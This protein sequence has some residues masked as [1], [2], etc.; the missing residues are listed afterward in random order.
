[1]DIDEKKNRLMSLD[2]LRGL[3][4]LMIT[5]L[6]PFLVTL[7]AALGFGSESWLPTQLRHVPW[8]G[9]R[10]EDLIF[11]LFLFMAGVTFPYSYAKQR[12]RGS[13]TARISGRIVCRAVTLMFLGMVTQGLFKFNFASMRIPSVLALIGVSWALAAFMYMWLGWRA[14][15]AVCLCALVGYGALMFFAHAPDYPA[16]DRFSMEGSFICWLDRVIYGGH[17]Y[18]PLYDP[19][20]LLR[21][22]TGMVTA[23]LGMFAG[24][25]IR[26][27]GVSGNRKALAIAG[28]GVA[29]LLAGLGLSAAGVCPVVK[30][31]W[32]PTFILVAG[33]WSAMLLAAFYW[34]VDVKMWRRW[35]FFFRVV[36][37]NS[38]TIY[39]AARIIPFSSINGFFLSGTAALLPTAWG[40]V[41]MSAGYIAVCWLF[42]YFLYRKNVF[43]RV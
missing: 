14:R 12:E 1:M 33:G 30:A 43:L 24:S 9:F 39:V 41:L 2:A 36:G 18:R 17:K 4:M 40:K 23:S 37:M 35:T 31:M 27:S 38:I 22:I 29:M 20:G 16:A 25:F 10:I 19:E 6:G 26:G 32:S 13:S 21:Y 34:I 7:C 28:A 11:P 42:L 15:L 3:D 8:E 5:G